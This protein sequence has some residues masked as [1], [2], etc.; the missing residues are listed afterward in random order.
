MI[1]KI[2]VFAPIPSANRK[3]CNRRESGRLHQL[4]H[5][6]AHI[7]PHRLNHRL[8]P[9]RPH[10][11]PHHSRHSPSPRAPPAALPP[12]SSR[13]AP[14]PPL[15]LLKSPQL[16]VNLLVAR[17]R[18]SQAIAAPPPHFAKSPSTRSPYASRIRLIAAVCRP[19]AAVLLSA[20]SARAPSA[21]RTSPAGCSP[22]PATPL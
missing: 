3:H 10:L 14:F 15:T 1:V 21:R 20:P 7:P 22:S 5:A 11:L 19:T 8:P 12:G 16:L 17:S 2:A 13:A 9:A 6:E 18:A 4:P